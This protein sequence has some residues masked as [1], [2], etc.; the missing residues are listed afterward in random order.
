MESARSF[1]RPMS[2]ASSATSRA[3]FESRHK[4]PL[5]ISSSVDYESSRTSEESSL[6]DAK[7][8][9]E[10]LA[11]RPSIPPT[12]FP[13]KRFAEPIVP[14]YA[15]YGAGGEGRQQQVRT[16]LLTP[17][18]VGKL[19]SVSPTSPT[20]EWKH[21]K[22]TPGEGFKNLP[23]EI[24]L[25]VLAALKKSHLE[26]GSLSCATCWMR[27]LTNVSLSSRKW[28]G[29]ARCLLYEDIQLNGTDSVLHTKKKFKIK[30]GTRLKLLRRTLRAR[31]DLAEF[32]KS[33]KV[34][35]IVSY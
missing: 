20:F 12:A 4:S 32:V 16:T 10:F 22:R 33:L 24:L 17:Q 25:V 1:P 2:P 26:V 14:A 5:S 29:A 6:S 35:Q 34:G 15:R 9:N 11:S 3:S 21:T 30:Y 28:W 13:G 7:L 8:N 27:D 31:P 23:E 19:G 18:R